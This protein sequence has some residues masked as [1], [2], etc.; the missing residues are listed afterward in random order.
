MIETTVRDLSE[1]IQWRG[2]WS[3]TEKGYFFNLDLLE[4]FPFPQGE[5][6]L[7][8]FLK[9]THPVGQSIFKKVFTVAY[10]RGGQ[11]AIRGLLINKSYLPYH[12]IFTISRNNK[13]KKEFCGEVIITNEVSS[14]TAFD[15]QEGYNAI[16]K[17]DGTLHSANKLFT[18]HL[19]D[20]Q[21][22]L[23]DEK[24][25]EELSKNK[26]Y[27]GD[28]LI[29][30]ND[31][32]ENYDCY[33]HPYFSGINKEKLYFATFIPKR[34]EVEMTQKT[35]DYGGKL[36]VI[37]EATAQI[38]HDVMNPLQIISSAM[39]QIDNKLK[40]LNLKDQV[41]GENSKMIYDSVDQIKGIFKDTKSLLR[42][43]TRLGPV[44]LQDVFRK[45]NM[46]SK[47][48]QSKIAIEIEITPEQDD[49]KK[50]YVN[51]NEGQLIQVLI[52]L[53]NNSCDALEEAYQKGKIREKWVKL[54]YRVTTS[55]IIISHIDSGKGIPDEYQ[56]KIF[57]SL[58][59]TKTFEEGTGLG[60]PLCKKII[61][62]FGGNI[63]LN[64]EDPNTR[65]DIK[66]SYLG[67]GNE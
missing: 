1:H 11:Y 55:H 63:S 19:A 41:I 33:I 43:D 39:N 58:F 38:L 62:S 17:N 25:I 42:N 45:A 14:I 20:I 54:N 10:A 35:Q 59:T 66:L 49:Y 7:F 50:I 52:N 27:Y 56:E 16:I 44:H 2:A 12:C 37:G 47:I 15:A 5:K 67:Q 13:N 22:N 53:I 29:K 64:I 18:Q 36:E 51:A 31:S 8:K 4:S 40:E 26:F 9:T 23:F 30:N 32:V 65:F 6:E 46:F 3:F 57:D 60:L 48:R 21:E 34:P 61:E 28:I 24:V